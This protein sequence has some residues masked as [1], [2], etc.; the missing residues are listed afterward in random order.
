MLDQL[1]GAAKPAGDRRADVDDM[2][3]HRLRVKHRVERHDAG[4]ERWADVEGDLRLRF[5]AEALLFLRQPEGRQQRRLL[6]ITI[7]SSIFPSVASL[8]ALAEAKL[9]PTWGPLIDPPPP[10]PD[11][12]WR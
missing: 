3:P 7:T 5:Q 2:P 9:T 10:A 11:R 4:H 1:V 6:R 12:G 8:S